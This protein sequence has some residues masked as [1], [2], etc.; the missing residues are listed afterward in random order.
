MYV[1]VLHD[2]SFQSYKILVVNF[3][4]WNYESWPI[5]KPRTPALANMLSSVSTMEVIIPPKKEKDNFLKDVWILIDKD[6]MA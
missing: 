6:K 1:H 5:I 4:G 2:V 3:I